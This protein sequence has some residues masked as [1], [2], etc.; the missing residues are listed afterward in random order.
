MWY[1]FV[2]NQKDLKDH[3]DEMIDEINFIGGEIDG[4]Q[5]ELIHIPIKPTLD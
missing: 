2:K 1:L 3:K 4:L 5:K